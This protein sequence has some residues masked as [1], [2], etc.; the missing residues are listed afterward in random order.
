MHVSKKISKLSKM[1][2]DF[3][4]LGKKNEGFSETKRYVDRTVSNDESRRF[5][6]RVCVRFKDSIISKGF[7]SL[8]EKRSRMS[9]EPNVRIR[10]NYQS[11]KMSVLRGTRGCFLS[12]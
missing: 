8:H 6:R 7:K 12:R 1:L 2:K 11:F 4:R 3:E 10:N 5:E 9:L